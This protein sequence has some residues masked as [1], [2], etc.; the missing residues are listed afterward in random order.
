MQFRMLDYNIKVIV[1]TSLTE[2]VHMK[3]INHLLVN[4]CNIIDISDI[5]R[6]LISRC[7]WHNILYYINASSH[8][9]N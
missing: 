2:N 6:V 4:R 8:R 5:L 9:N 1:K 7:E 3:D